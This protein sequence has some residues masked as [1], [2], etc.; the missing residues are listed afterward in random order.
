MQY[1]RF[2]PSLEA[3]TNKSIP[4][5]VTGTNSPGLIRVVEKTVTH[6]SVLSVVSNCFHNFCHGFVLPDDEVLLGSVVLLL[7]V[8][9][10]HEVNRLVQDDDELVLSSLSSFWVVGWEDFGCSTVLVRDPSRAALEEGPGLSLPCW[11]ACS[12][13][14]ARTDFAKSNKPCCTMGVGLV[15]LRCNCPFSGCG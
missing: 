5:T 11:T 15:P 3:I 8:P 6:S 12:F 13:F 2:L 1:N 14:C 4:A 9:D 7:L 10:I